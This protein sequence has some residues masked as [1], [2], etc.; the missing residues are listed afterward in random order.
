MKPKHPMEILEE[1][2]GFEAKPS[3]DYI[4][5]AQLVE[6]VRHYFSDA[7]M[8]SEE[9]VQKVTDEYITKVEV[10]L[11][12]AKDSYFQELGYKAGYY[13]ALERMKR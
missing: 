11:Y 10:G 6:S 8:P 13:A 9:E 4:Q 1:W 7:N 12:D 3:I 5:F 2:R